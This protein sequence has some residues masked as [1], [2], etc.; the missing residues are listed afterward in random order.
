MFPVIRRFLSLLLLCLGVLILSAC[1]IPEAGAAETVASPAVFPPVNEATAPPAPLPTAAPP[2][3]VPVASGTVEEGDRLLFYGDWQAAS[4]AYHAAWVQESDPEKRA[5]A[6][7]GMGR[8][9]F[10]MQDYAAAAQALQTLIAEFPDSTYRPPAYITLAQL[11]SA[12]GEYAQAANAYAFYLGLRPGLVDSYI[13]ELRGD[14]LIAAGDPLA[15]VEAYQQALAAPRV[16]ETFSLEIKIA[17]A[18]AAAGE[19]DT[20]LVAYQDLYNR[21]ANEYTRAYLDYQMGSVYL[22]SGQPD[23]AYTVYLDAVENY[24]LSY[25]T[26]QG[27]IWIVEAGYP[28][29]EFD[30]GLVDYFAGQYA[31]AIAAFDRYLNQFPEAEHYDI[32]RYYQ[33]LAFR[34][35][36]EHEQAIEYLDEIIAALPDSE[37]WADAW[38]EKAYTQ[39]AFQQRY[40]AARQTLVD[41]VAQSPAHPRAPAFLMEAGRIAERQGALDDAVELWQRLTVEYPA[42]DQVADAVFLAGIARYRQADFSRARQWFE[43]YLGYASSAGERAAA[44]FWM[45]KCAQAMGEAGGAEAAFQQAVAADP[46]GYYSERA[47]DILLGREVFSPPLVYDLGYDLALERPE[48]EAWLRSAFG[49]SQ[50]VDLTFPGVLAADPRLIRGTELHRLG[51]RDQARSEFDALR[52]DVKTDPLASFLLADYLVELGYYRTAIF[53]ARQVL[54]LNLMDDAATLGAPAW[55]NHVRFGAYFRELVVPAAVEND[56]HPLFL[57]AVIRQESLFAAWVESSAGALGLMQIIPSTGE[58]LA[59]KLGWPPGYATEDLYRP[60]VSLRF[61]AE[62]LAQQ[63]DYFNGDLMAALAAYNAGPGNAAIWHALS[64]GDPDLF[65]EIV[66]FDETR[67]YL[68]G[69]YELFAIYRLLYDRTP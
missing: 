44:Y 10:H 28:V 23:Q 16:G 14:A 61:G 56:L 3:E 46:T 11:H 35:L 65:V 50:E 57:Y 41:F 12:Q 4:E 63:R 13:Q 2:V 45:G 7:L 32:V 24:P 40:E 9:A 42:A 25:D 17:D 52:Q 6:L 19:Y 34:S 18:Y 51:L 58:T 30:R 21:T 69:V 48:A 60:L 5:A 1:Q 31:L 29:S 59:Q 49:L 36:G 33:A 54:D 64:Q 68:K 66:R 27:L 55:F 39:W 22:Q 38:W 37:R 15:A 67:R 47:R 26:Y 20:A 43:R 53:A 8:A 62:Y